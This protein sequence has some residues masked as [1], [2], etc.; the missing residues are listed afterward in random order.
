[1]LIISPEIRIFEE[2]SVNLRTI[3]GL[4]AH[5]S[6]VRRLQT[7]ENETDQQ[8]KTPSLGRNSNADAHC[9]LE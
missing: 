6:C 8:Y 7:L 4:Y 1:M 9:L 5:I 3:F 2:K